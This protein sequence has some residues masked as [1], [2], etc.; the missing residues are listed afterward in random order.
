MKTDSPF[1]CPLNVRPFLNPTPPLLFRSPLLFGFHTPKDMMEV[2]WFRRPVGGLR[3]DSS[4]WWKS[5]RDPFEG[6]RSDSVPP[7]SHRLL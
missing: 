4:E 1:P 7:P 6:G 3:E 5:E 2:G